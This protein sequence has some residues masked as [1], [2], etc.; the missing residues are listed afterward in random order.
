MRINRK[1]A[2]WYKNVTATQVIT[3]TIQCGVVY[4]G[5]TGNSNMVCGMLLRH[6]PDYSILADAR[7][8]EHQVITSTLRSAQ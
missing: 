1:Y 6:D 7:G 8:V 3:P 2:A 5:D 4:W